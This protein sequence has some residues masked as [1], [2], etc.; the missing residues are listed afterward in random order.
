MCIVIGQ[1]VCFHS[2]MKYENNQMMIA[3][4]VFTDLLLNSP[5]HSPQFSP[6]N[7]GM[8]NMFYF[9]KR[10]IANE[11]YKIDQKLSINWLVVYYE[12]SINSIIIDFIQMVLHI[13]S[14]LCFY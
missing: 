2:A 12:F 7:E 9:L 1:Q 4:Q 5:K 11:C 3:S 6:G 10:Y 13:I 14:T 8:E